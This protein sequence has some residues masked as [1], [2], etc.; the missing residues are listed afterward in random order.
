MNFNL[1]FFEQIFKSKTPALAR[2][3][4][5]QAIRFTAPSAVQE[6]LDSSIAYYLKRLDEMESLLSSY[7][8]PAQEW[9]QPVHL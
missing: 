3:F 6:Y 7:P 1:E 8:L 2:K 9:Q 4:S 5:E